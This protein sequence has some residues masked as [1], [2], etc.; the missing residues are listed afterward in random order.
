MGHRA[1]TL[2]IAPLIDPD[3]ITQTFAFAGPGDAILPFN[4][5]VTIGNKQS[6]VLRLPTPHKIVVTNTGAGTGT[7]Q[8]QGE[9]L[10]NKVI[11]E[12]FDNSLATFTT[13]NYFQSI[14]SIQILN[15]SSPA[16]TVGLDGQASSVFFMSAST[17]M[18]E[19]FN[20][21]HFVEVAFGSD[22]DWSIFHTGRNLEDPNVDINNIQEFPHEFLSGKTA[23]DPFEENDGNYQFKPNY[24]RIVI[25]NFVTGGLVY[26]YKL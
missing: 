13:Q 23:A 5:A 16:I 22:F 8:I 7:L 26:T 9:D 18:D 17:N 1:K 3:A 24:H 19:S 4:G 14:Y 20:P 12:S 21:G 11:T 6:T 10:R 2:T 25:T 15:G